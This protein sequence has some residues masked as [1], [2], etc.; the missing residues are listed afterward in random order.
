MVFQKL[1]S[2]LSEDELHIY[3]DGSSFG[4]P[5][6][7]G[8]SFVA[9]HRGSLIKQ[10]SKGLGIATNGYAEVRAILLAVRWLYSNQSNHAVYIFVD[11]RRAINLATGSDSPAW[12]A[13]EVKEIR[14]L[15][16]IVSTGRRVA[17]YWVPGHAGIAGNEAADKLAKKAAKGMAH[18]TDFFPRAVGL[19]RPGPA[20]GPGLQSSCRWPSS[21]QLPA[22]PSRS[23]NLE[24]KPAS[25]SVAS[26]DLE[27]R[28]Q[29]LSHS[30]RLARGLVGDAEASC[31]RSPPGSPCSWGYGSD[32][33]DSPWHLSDSDE[34]G[35]AAPLPQAD[36]VGIEPTPPVG[37]SQTQAGLVPSRGSG[38]HDQ[39]ETETPW[40]FSAGA[41]E[42]PRVYRYVEGSAAAAALASEYSGLAAPAVSSPARPDARLAPGHA[43]SSAPPV[44]CGESE[45]SGLLPSSGGGGSALADPAFLLAPPSA[46]DGWRCTDAAPSPLGAVPRSRCGQLSPLSPLSNGD[47]VPAVV[48]SA[49]SSVG[50]DVCPPSGLAL[51]SST[52]GSPMRPAP[53]ATMSSA[54]PPLSSE[55]GFPCLP[56]SREE[57]LSA[58][59]VSL[60]LLPAPLP[61]LEGKGGVAAASLTGS[62]P[63]AGSDPQ[64]RVET[65][66]PQLLSSEASLKSLARPRPRFR[67]GQLSPLSSRLE[68]EDVPVLA[69]STTFSSARPDARSA[70]GHVWRSSLPVTPVRL[71]AVAMPM[72][73]SVP[74]ALSCECT[75]ASSLSPGKR[76]SNDT[77]AS[78]LLLGAPSPASEGEEVN[79]AVLSPADSLSFGSGSRGW[80]ET[81]SPRPFSSGDCYRPAAAHSS[82][83]SPPPPEGG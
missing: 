47:V 29:S 27:A 40:L 70:P 54:P 36:T 50:S 37:P 55:S 19:S 25:A 61:G 21:P 22:T 42:Q 51:S 63:L 17:F 80:V 31:A 83:L 45:P 76:D 67:G 53:V 23:A 12:C 49:F 16:K 4:N 66:S 62:H 79:A 52:S 20:K 13:D 75:L 1:L 64:C 78:A 72:T 2:T 10:G 41:C 57:V 60:S 81:E 5:G 58:T 69:A 82:V 46:S 34:G 59:A 15:L 28:E 14:R 44:F 26:V 68:G 18:S 3:T 30:Q 39:E 38:L 77:A 56:P 71:V 33:G 74:S 48:A 6:P 43:Q 8:A 7:A 35:A 11:N 9:Y 32:Y 73:S 24:T 65:E